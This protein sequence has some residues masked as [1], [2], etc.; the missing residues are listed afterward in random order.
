[1][2]LANEMKADLNNAG[3]PPPS[4]LLAED[5]DVMLGMGHWALPSGWEGHGPAEP[6]SVLSKTLMKDFGCGFVP[7]IISTVMQNVQMTPEWM[8]LLMSLLNADF[9]DGSRGS[10]GEQSQSCISVTEGY[11]T[12]SDHIFQGLI[13]GCLILHMLSWEGRREDWRSIFGTAGKWTRVFS[14]P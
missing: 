13:P 8:G 7:I 11:L 2:V 1:M 4:L 9:L 12:A 3:K 5:P 14:I 10:A 6:R